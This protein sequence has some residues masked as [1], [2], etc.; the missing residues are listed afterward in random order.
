MRDI[1]VS[2]NYDFVT[3]SKL[4]LL[5]TRQVNKPRPERI[6]TLFR[7]PADCDGGLLSQRTIFPN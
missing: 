2:V 3:E 5:A 1:G 6:V 7:K 4:T